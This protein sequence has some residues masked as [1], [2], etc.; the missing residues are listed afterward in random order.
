MDDELF[1]LWQAALD[2]LVAHNRAVERCRRAYLEVSRHHH[3]A[4]SRFERPDY[5]DE[6]IAACDDTR[7]TAADYAAAFRRYAAARAGN[8]P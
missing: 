3:L 6:W 1:A 5:L 2:T 8:S 7:Q 4:A